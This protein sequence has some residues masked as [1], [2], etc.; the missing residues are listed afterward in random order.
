MVATRQA[1]WRDGADDG[2]HDDLIWYAAGIHQ[3]R[4]LTPG[5]DNFFQLLVQFLQGGPP[6]LQQQMGAVAAQ[7]ND[8]RSLGH[9]SQVHGTYADKP[10]WPRFQGKQALWQECAHNQW[11]FLP[12]HRAYLAEFEAVVRQHIKDLD[13]PAETWGLPYWNYSD[14]QS[15]QGRLQMPAPLADEF[16]PGDVHVKGV[17]ATQDGFPNPLFIPV[18]APRVEPDDEWATARDALQRPHFANQ[19]DRARISFGGGV[20]ER[21]NDAAL[22]HLA[23]EM[24]ELDRQP[25]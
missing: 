7:W 2:W 25:H 4:L 18:R 23:R 21:P 24:G 20:I 3:M 9:Q 8:P 11:F 1:A 19:D 17:E 12:W 14:F 5:L 15:D 6:D 16:L 10:S 13:G 22:F